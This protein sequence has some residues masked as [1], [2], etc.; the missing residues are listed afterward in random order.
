MLA[1]EN[2]LTKRVD[3]QGSF[4]TPVRLTFSNVHKMHCFTRS[5]HPKELLVPERV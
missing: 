5:M 2:H 4:G 3:L 1:M